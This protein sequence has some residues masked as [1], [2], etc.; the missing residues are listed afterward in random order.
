ML[1]RIYINN[2]WYFTGDDNT[3]QIVSIPHTIKEIPYNYF[4]QKIYQFT[5]V[6]EKEIELNDEIGHNL[7]LTFEGVGQSS[8]VYIN[9]QLVTTH[10]GG[11]D[12]FSIN[13]KDLVIKG[14]NIIKVIVDASEEQNFPPF[15]KVIDYLCYGGIYRDVY[16]DVCSSNY[17]EDIFVMPLH[18]TKWH[19]KTV[20]KLH[21]A[22]KYEASIYFKDELI[23]KKMVDNKDT[24]STVEFEFENPML[25]DL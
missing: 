4:D 16:I 23:E 22:S 2:D 18:D 17:I 25:W 10:Y 11:Y 9:D 15:G 20:V 12:K 14:K 6:Y 1:K 21:N 3:R 8:K 19:A 7:F 13:I 5:A 24:E